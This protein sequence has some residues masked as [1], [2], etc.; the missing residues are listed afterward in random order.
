MGRG[1]AWSALALFSLGAGGFWYL[2]RQD[3]PLPDGLSGRLVYVSDRSGIDTLY[4]RS[5]P[6][7]EERRLTFL[8]EPTREPALSPDGFQVAF[9]MGGRIGL[10]SLLTGQ[11]QILTLGI[12]WRDASPSWRA[13][14]K[15]LVVSSRR[16]GESNADVHFLLLDPSGGEPARRPLTSTPGLDEVSPVFG[17]DGTFVVFVRQDNL[18]R[19]D[20]PAGRTRRLTGG[21]RKF[22]CPRFASAGRLLCLWSEDKKY[23]IDIMDATGKNQE[24]LAQGP[25]YYRSLTP[26]PDGRFLATTFTFDLSFEPSDALKLRQTEDVRLLDARGNPMGTLARSWR[27]ANHSPDWGR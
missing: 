27:F 7:G 8:L 3:A 6:G 17:P 13:D 16:A 12:E 22:R 5:L 4:V 11:V 21:F 23:G 24:T 20:L 25:V 26:S 19:L 14:G 18:F 9:S 1:L 15:G 10:V 2:E